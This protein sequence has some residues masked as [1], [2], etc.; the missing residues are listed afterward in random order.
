MEIAGVAFEEP[1]VAG[2]VVVVARYFAAVEGCARAEVDST[3]Q[4]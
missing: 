3:H 4:E 2:A 1:V